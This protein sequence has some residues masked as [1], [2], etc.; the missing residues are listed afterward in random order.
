MNYPVDP[1]TG[2]SDSLALVICRGTGLCNLDFSDRKV[3]EE[4]EDYYLCDHHA[5]E[6][7]YK[8]GDH[9]NNGFERAHIHR[10]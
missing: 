8:W 9:N 4:W 5:D 3:A 7:L 6:L 2:A 1:K 10:N